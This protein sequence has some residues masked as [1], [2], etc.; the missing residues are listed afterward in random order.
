MQLPHP[1]TSMTTLAH[2]ASGVTPARASI[3]S[4]SAAPASAPASSSLPSPSSSLPPSLP[5]PPPQQVRRAGTKQAGSN[6][7]PFFLAIAAP[8]SSTCCD[9]CGTHHIIVLL[10]CDKVSVLYCILR[11][12]GHE[13]KKLFSCKHPCRRY[14]A[15]VRT[16][17][18]MPSPFRRL[19]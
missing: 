8:S 19:T 17:D 3:L 11:P 14:S 18:H 5:P 16:C 12:V 2:H 4:S 1:L 6:D 10:E 7:R 15:L 13:N 9:V